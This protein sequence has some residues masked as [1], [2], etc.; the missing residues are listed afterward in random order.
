M[1]KQLG[2]VTLLI[3]LSVSALL[4]TGCSNRNK[5]YVPCEP[6]CEPS[7]SLSPEPYNSIEPEQ[8]ASPSYEQ[9]DYPQECEDAYTVPTQPF[10]CDPSGNCCS[11]GVIVQVRN[12][13]MCLLG[14]QYPLDV[15]ITAC[16]DVCEVILTATLPAGVTF[17]RSQPQA[18]IQ[19]DQAIWRFAHLY[20][21]QNVTAKIWLKC[22]REGDLCT[23]FCVKATPVAFCAIRC[24]KPVLIC[25]KCGPAEVCPGQPIPYT[26]TVTNVGTCTARNVLVTD[27]LPDELE[28]ASGLRILNFRLGDLEP[29][30]TKKIN[31]CVT[32]CKRGRVCNTIVASASNANQT[33]CEACT[34]ISCCAIECNK[35]GPKE[36]PVGQNAD[37]QI[38]LVN[39]GDRTL[40]E[41]VVT[42][43][44]PIT[45]TIAA[46][47]GA[48]LYGKQAIWRLRELKPGEGVTFPITLTTCSPGLFTNHVHV[49]TCEG[50]QTCCEFETNWKGRPALDVCVTSCENPICV[51]DTTQFKIVVINKGQE[52]DSNIQ[53]VVNFPPELIPVEG[54]GAAVA[55]IEGP[56]VEFVP[57]PRLAPQ[58]TLE[59]Y[60]TAEASAPGD[61]RPRIEVSSDF[62][63]N[64]ITQEESLIVN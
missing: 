44:A 26:V 6:V 46:A 39:T 14:D 28:H 24:A 27:P 32:A 15:D 7:Q 63:K 60:I 43:S 20:K 23:C 2:I 1:R 18:R 58:Q 25:E 9:L 61:L 13:K 42:D 17:L 64:P 59:Y 33:S 16:C 11:N 34:C 31:F 55:R 8:P 3:F 40:Y 5:C 56:T 36:V 54:S 21:G 30:Q 62:I 22:D 12:P 52:V 41:I 48:V 38:H 47:P 10:P 49:E 37:Y 53:V 50:C 45:T 57:I 29:C 4:W 19:G 51:G 35:T